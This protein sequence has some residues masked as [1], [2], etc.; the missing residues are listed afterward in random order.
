MFA[1]HA[2]D[3]SIDRTLFSASSDDDALNVKWA[4]ARVEYSTFIDTASDAIDVDAASPPS[5]VAH[6]TFA[7]IGGDA[8]DLSFSDIT[9]TNNNVRECADKGISIG[10]VS[11]VVA[12][13]N[14]I[15][16]CVIGI[17]VKDLSDALLIRNRLSGNDTG[18][19]LYQKKDIFGGAT[20]TLEDTIFE[21]NEENV[22]VDP[23]SAVNYE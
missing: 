2:S 9:L 19:S 14:V 17:A 20:A 6:N 21:G 4:R 1:L 10:E 11:T 12:E 13:E 22:S 8:I 7:R 5:L 18:I 16:S 3:V 23:G 15:V